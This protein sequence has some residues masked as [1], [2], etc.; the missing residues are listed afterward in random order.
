MKKKIIEFENKV[1]IMV[2]DAAI[3]DC[4]YVPLISRIN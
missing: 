1:T 3:I 2:T 4:G